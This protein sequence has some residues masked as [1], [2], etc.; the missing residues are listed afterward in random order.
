MSDRD[1]NANS[2]G[3]ALSDDAA[4]VDNFAIARVFQSQ[5]KIAY[6]RDAL[7]TVQGNESTIVIDGDHLNELLPN[8]AHLIP[9]EVDALFTGLCI[10]GA[11]K[12]D[13][14]AS[15]FIDYSFEV[16]V[17]TARQVLD[18]QLIAASA[19]E[20][21]RSSSEPAEI[22]LI[23]TIPESVSLTAPDVVTYTSSRVR[24]LLLNAQSS[25]RIANPYFDSE[26]TV[27]EDIASLPR[28]GVSTKI[29]TRETEDPDPQLRDT[30][31]ALYQH[32]DGHSR[33]HLDVRD[34]YET[35][36]TTGRQQVATHAKMVVIDE[37]F[38]YIGSANLTY[39]SLLRN[40]EFGV[41]LSGEVT[42][43]VATLFDDVFAHA[44]QVDLPV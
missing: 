5:E 23:A 24:E 20:D 9:R 7:E 27:V 25:V 35:D 6:V 40:F 31:K 33:S 28:R 22:N 2:S 19:L 21:A 39:H 32:L 30:L 37:E 18:Q 34:L 44:R 42:E 17:P 4:V 14:P 8:N 1:S 26:Q 43:S 36:P 41:L 11:A 29:L 10:T 13:I 38:C 15:S 12:E 16:D 3:Q